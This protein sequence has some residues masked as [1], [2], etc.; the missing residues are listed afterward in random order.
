MCL[1]NQFVDRALTFRKRLLNYLSK[2]IHPLQRRRIDAEDLLM[3]VI[4]RCPD[5]VEAILQWSDKRFYGWLLTATTR[6]LHSQHR[7]HLDTKR[8]SVRRELHDSDPE[9]AAQVAACPANPAD[10]PEQHAIRNEHGQLLKSAL[11]K[12]SEQERDIMRL[13]YLESR[14]V[15]EVAWLEGISIEACRKR[16][17]RTR[18][19]LA[20]MLPSSM[21][22]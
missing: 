2:L 14:S 8:R 1:H 20:R 10:S 9:A 6:Y 16:D 19:K 17:F 7:R 21:R 11:E 3:A 4:E 12:L 5:N 13:R 15:E 22:V 18:L